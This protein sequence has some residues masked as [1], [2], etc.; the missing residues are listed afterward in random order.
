MMRYRSIG[1]VGLLTAAIV[2]WISCGHDQAPDDSEAPSTR[3]DALTTRVLLK[4][5]VVATEASA[6]KIPDTLRGST[7]VTHNGSFQYSVPIWV[8]PGRAG[9][10]PQLALNYDSAASDGLVGR[11]WILQATSAITRCGLPGDMRPGGPFRI[12]WDANDVLCM[13]GQILVPMKAGTTKLFDGQEF[14]TEEDRFMKVVQR[15]WVDPE[16]PTGFDVY[17]KDGRILHY[18]ATAEPVTSDGSVLRAYLDYRGWWRQGETIASGLPAP[19]YVRATW[20]LAY[21]TDRSGNRIDYTYALDDDTSS[22]THGYTQRLATIKYTSAKRPG[23]TDLPP[24]KE[25][26]LGYEVRPDPSFQYLAGVRIALKQRLNAISVKAFDE[27]NT[28]RT[29]R[30]FSFAYI[31]GSATK[32]SLLRSITECVVELD[33]SQSCL[34]PTT[35]DYEPGSA[36]F[37]GGFVSGG[38]T[39]MP[40]GIGALPVDPLVVG[41]FNGDGRDDVVFIPSAGGQMQMLL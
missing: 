10:Q 38:K 29:L 41:D 8:P 26:D 12:G 24:S 37:S 27:G 22:G 39:R 23:F 15:G 32:K 4:G 19:Q 1:L 20:Q 3:S 25:I 9:M 40:G 35:F 34:D 33:T 2:V 36:S 16:G 30:T 7:K 11:G 17:T 5:A 18:G 14:R 6:G 21:V 31:Q 28:L 13:D